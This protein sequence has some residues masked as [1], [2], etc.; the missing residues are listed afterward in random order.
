MQFQFVELGLE[1]L[2]RGG[3]VLVLGTVVLA[4]HDGIGR[5]MSDAHRR[6]GTVDVLAAGSRGAVDIDAQISR[7]DVHFDAVVDFRRHEYRRERGVAAIAGIEWRLAHQSMDTDLGPQPAK[8]VVA[9]E[10]DAGAL[11]PRH[12]PR[13]HLQQFG[14]ETASLA[15]TQVHPQQHLRPVLSLGTTGAGLNIEKSVAGIQLAGEHS[16]E[17]QIG[18]DSAVAVQIAH[19]F[20]NRCFVAFLAGQRQ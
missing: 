20:D 2:H 15:P 11:D 18:D 3:A 7:I 16:L 8:S 17:F 13:R 19:H 12:F 5:Q 10:T 6:L 4:L 14:L 9:L 1:L